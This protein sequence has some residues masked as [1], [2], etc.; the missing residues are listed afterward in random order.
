MCFRYLFQEILKYPG[1]ERLKMKVW[2]LGD[3]LPMCY[4]CPN[5]GVEAEN[6][7]SGLIRAL[8]IIFRARSFFV[9]GTN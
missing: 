3:W 5:A 2:T 6:S 1:D 4:D 9:S 7:W 8:S